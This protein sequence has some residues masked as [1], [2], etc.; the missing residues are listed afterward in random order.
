MRVLP[1]NVSLKLKKWAQR[2]FK[3]AVDPKEYLNKILNEFKTN[4]FYYSL[5]PE[6][7]GNDYENFFFSTKTGYCEY[8]AGTFV[9]LARL[10]GI[11][12]RIV[13]GYFGGSYNNL[14]DFYTFKQHDEHSWVE[15]FLDGKFQI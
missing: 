9:I 3:K 11:P 2:N 12:S 8:F 13:T 6:T 1:N 14:G 7:Q 5:T 15:I 10:V 4:N